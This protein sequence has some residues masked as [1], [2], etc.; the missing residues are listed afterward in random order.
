MLIVGYQIFFLL[1]VEYQIAKLPKMVTNMLVNKILVT[2]K[3]NY[4]MLVKSPNVGYQIVSYQNVRYQFNLPNFSMTKL[5]VNTLLV[6][7]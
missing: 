6:A 4:Q 7:K 3:L 5:L 1:I 2:K